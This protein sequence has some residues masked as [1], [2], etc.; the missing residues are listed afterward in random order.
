MQWLDLRICIFNCNA[1][2]SGCTVNCSLSND[3]ER[4]KS[5]QYVPIHHQ[6]NCYLTVPF[7]IHTIRHVSCTQTMCNH[8]CLPVIYRQRCDR[9][10]QHPDF[11]ECRFEIQS[12]SGDIRCQTLLCS[13]NHMLCNTIS[14]SNS[15]TQTAAAAAC[16]LPPIHVPINLPYSTLLNKLYFCCFH[17]CS[18][19]GNNHRRR[20]AVRSPAQ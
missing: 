11:I 15:M 18:L 9:S 20:C 8:T 12:I 7:E 13:L 10:T 6:Q 16:L 2:S 4:H 5:N 1:F 19:V 14:K 3:K 17:S